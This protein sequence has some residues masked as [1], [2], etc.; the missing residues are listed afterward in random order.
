MDKPVILIAFANESHSSSNYLRNLPKEA[1]ELRKSL[2]IAEENGLCEFLIIYNA[3]FDSII[4]VFQNPKYRNR[5]AIFHFGGHAGS[6]N[7]LLKN[8]KGDMALT[9]GEGLV[10]FLANQDSL[11]LVFLNGCH[12]QK[13]AHSLSTQGVP[14]VIGTSFSILDYVATDLSISFYRSLTLGLEIERAWKE[15]VHKILA[16]EEDTSPS[17]FYHTDNIFR[18]EIKLSEQPIINFPWSLSIGIGQEDVKYWNLPKAA[19]NPLFGLP[20]IENSYDLPNEPYRYLQA[21]NKEWSRNFFGRGEYI[22]KLYHRIIG[23]QSSPIILL[24]G[25]SGVGKSSLLKA[26][27][28]PRL[29]T[30]M[31]VR[32]T[33]RTK[34]YGLSKDLTTVLYDA[35]RQF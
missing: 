13:I 22:Q 35:Y 34:A 23:N 21:Y 17:R 25:Q 15:S 18:E 5:I 19:N 16:Q 7:L 29:A 12:T 27:I 3:T 30:K 24:H 8:D 20:T 6:F 14:A 28:I 31:V 32:Y 2:S 1:I 11:Q 9:N 4:S 33:Q 26:G 10:P